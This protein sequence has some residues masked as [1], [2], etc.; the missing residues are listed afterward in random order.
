MNV[1]PESIGT[2]QGTEGRIEEGRKT[3]HVLTQTIEGRHIHAVACHER[4]RMFR[5]DGW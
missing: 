5:R 1:T 2:C 4:I 3:R